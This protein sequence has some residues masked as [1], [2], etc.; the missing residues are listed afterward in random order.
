[1][2]FPMQQEKYVQ[3]QQAVRGW[4]GHPWTA[5][6]PCLVWAHRDWPGMC[7]QVRAGARHGR[8]PALLS[9]VLQNSLA[10]SLMWAGVA[11]P[12]QSNS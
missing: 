4:A 12:E 10:L 3:H 11:D 2:L 8:S 9:S 7:E 5:N 1:M 6:T